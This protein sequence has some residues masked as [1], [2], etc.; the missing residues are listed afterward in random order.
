MA[1]LAEDSSA[2]RGSGGGKNRKGK[3]DNMGLDDDEFRE[4]SKAM[5]EKSKVRTNG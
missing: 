3:T 5:R 1:N 4:F 2:V